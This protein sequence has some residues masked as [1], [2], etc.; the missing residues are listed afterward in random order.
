MRMAK[1]YAYAWECPISYTFD[2]LFLQLNNQ[3]LVDLFG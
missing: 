2:V 3:F 1:G